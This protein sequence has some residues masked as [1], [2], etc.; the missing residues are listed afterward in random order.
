MS[1]TIVTE[2]MKNDMISLRR[3]GW[4]YQK[5]ADHVG[6]GKTTARTWCVKELGSTPSTISQSPRM[7]NL[8][9]ADDSS[10]RYN[11]GESILIMKGPY[12]GK[13]GIILEEGVM[14]NPNGKK[15][16]KVNIQN[17]KVDWI[18]NVWM[19]SYLRP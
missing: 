5:I 15:F 13:S 11:V 7:K 14:S 9:I 17:R 8:K 3:Q 6:V 4:S 16:Y 19:I 2:T 12:A 1:T 10:V 18:L